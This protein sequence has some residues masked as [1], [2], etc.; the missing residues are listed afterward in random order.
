M[1]NYLEI[2]KMA[3]ITFPFIALLMSIPFILIQYHKYGSINF[4]KVLI[5]YSLTL[6]LI[7]AY[8]LV[9]L[10]LPKISE[11]ALLTTPRM[12]LIPFTFIIDLVRNTSFN[13][14][15]GHTYLSALRQSYFYVPLY[16]IFLTLP[17]G[18]YLR[19]YFKCD[20]KKTILYSFLLSLFFELTQLSGLYFI[21]PRGYRLFDVDDLLLNILGGMVGYTI[22]QP[23]IRILPTPKQIELVAKEKG[24]KVSGFRRTTCLG[25]DLFIFLVFDLTLEIFL[26]RVIPSKYIITLSVVLFYFIIPALLK[27]QTLGEKFLNI[28]VTDNDGKASILRLFYRNIIF[29]FIYFGIPFIIGCMTNNINIT[30]ETRDFIGTILMGVMLLIFIV[31]LIKYVFTSKKMI[32]E[33]ITKTKLVSTIK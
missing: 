6:Y 16:N 23:L 1:S 24:K 29:I 11:V 5:T 2:I 19:Y 8:F 22:A 20:L 18:I 13:I 25:L 32:Y 31:S 10:P 27:C 33:K 9:I 4:L 30:V 12:Q 3:I 17:F 28:Q 21:Y 14:A 7:C 26:S 15:N